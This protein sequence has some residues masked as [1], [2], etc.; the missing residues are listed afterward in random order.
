MIALTKLGPVS[1]KASDEDLLIESTPATDL[2]SRRSW[3]AIALNH[4]DG[5]KTALDIEQCL[6]LGYGVSSGQGISIPYE[7]F[8]PFAERV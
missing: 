7:F 8:Q 4:E 2:S 5:L 3:P 6:E 1:V